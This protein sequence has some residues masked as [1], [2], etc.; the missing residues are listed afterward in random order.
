MHSIELKFATHITGYHFIHCS[1]FG[2]FK[3]NSLSTVVRRGILTHYSLWRQI[4]RSFL[5]S[6]RYFR[7]NGR[8]P[9]YNSNLCIFTEIFTNSQIFKHLII[10]IS[11]E[12]QMTSFLIFSY[13]SLFSKRQW[14]KVQRFNSFLLNNKVAPITLWSSWKF[15]LVT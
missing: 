9:C 10:N 14:M 13:C 3:I 12:N 11:I 7:E 15:E 8:M 5:V 6:K 4:I 2:E 1:D